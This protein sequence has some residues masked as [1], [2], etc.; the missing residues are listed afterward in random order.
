MSK[1][2][3]SS[4]SSVL[5]EQFRGINGGGS[6]SPGYYS[7]AFTGD[8]YLYTHG[9][10]FR[11][12]KI[13]NEV[14][15]GL[16]L[17]FNNSNG[18][19]MLTD[20]ATQLAAVQ[21]VGTISGDAIITAT[22][23][24]GDAKSYTLTHAAPNNLS[25][26]GVTYGSIPVANNVATLNAVNLPSIILDAYGHITAASNVTLDVTKVKGTLL[27]N[28]LD[29]FYVLGASGNSIQSPSYIDTIYFNKDGTFK[30]SLIYEGNDKLEDKYAAKQNATNSSVGTVYLSDAIDGTA[31]AESGY[32][33]ATPLAVSSA[34]ASANRYAEDLF[35]QNDA[36]VF[37]GTITS[38]GVF[39]S[40]NERILPNVVN[41]TTTITAQTFDYRAGYTM[42]FTDSGTITLG[43]GANAVEFTVEPG[44]V[45]LAINDK[46]Q[47]YKGSDFTVIQNNISGGLVSATDL[48]GI[49]TGSGTRTLSAFAYPDSG[50]PVLQYNNGLQWAAV[51][52]LWRTIYDVNSNSIQ[53]KNIVLK[54]ATG[55]GT[56]TPLTVTFGTEGS[57]ATITYTL[58]PAAIVAGAAHNLTITQSSTQFVYAPGTGADL[59]IGAG[60]KLTS[61]TSGDNTT[62]TLNH[63]AATNVYSTGVLGTVTTDS[64]GHVTSITQVTSLQNPESLYIGT[65]SQAYGSYKGDSKLGLTFSGNTDV[66]VTPQVFNEVS[67]MVYDTNK[68][69]ASVN[70]DIAITHR[71]RPI[72]IIDTENTTTNVL[73]DSSATALSLKEGTH[74]TLSNSSGTV[75]IN[76]AWREV[77]LY[78][79]TQNTLAQGTLA[80][81][82]AL[83]FG[84]D[85]LADS[86]GLGIC[87]TEIDT[88]GNITYVK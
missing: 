52:S 11:I 80:D 17:S 61:S 36:L 21:V 63:P 40:H 72:N 8:G 76:A 27:T 84:S 1:L 39:K 64:Y 22:R 62:Y 9:C 16:G 58:H 38:S 41:N 86:N 78:T 42:K 20:G 24:S 69:T 49:V 88:N 55:N 44:D 73:I 43:T 32:T 34:V 66:T 74:I 56:Q 57:N 6:S 50:T 25:Y 45:L 48:N 31:D 83:I 51:N 46:N 70:F 71:Y 28:E 67:G 81:T 13:V 35:T 59:V 33:A 29:N 79:V 30:A 15:Q 18:Q 7:I 87:W 77:D 14:A 65:A 10:K 53:D 19:L 54:T 60:L 26:D 85:F 4:S 23:A 3:F 82:S 12:Y 37:I 2:I 75:T 5:E 47:V 68:R